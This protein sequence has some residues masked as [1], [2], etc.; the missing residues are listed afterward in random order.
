[1]ADQKEQS[2]DKQNGSSKSEGTA[3]LRVMLQRRENTNFDWKGFVQSRFKQKDS[4][5]TM[6][7][8]IKHRL[9]SGATMQGHLETLKTRQKRPWSEHL[10][11]YQNEA[12]RR[13]GEGQFEEAG[14]VITKT[15]LER[16]RH[17]TVSLPEEERLELAAKVMKKSEEEKQNCRTMRTAIRDQQQ[18]IEVQKPFVR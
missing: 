8:F 18:H 9:E 3:A 2:P 14:P 4:C 15:T 7:D 11:E 17:A 10:Q 13:N 5:G 12:D 6:R 1:M 16:M